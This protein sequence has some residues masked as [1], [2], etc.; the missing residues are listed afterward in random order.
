MVL[1]RI[2]IILAEHCNCI[3]KFCY[4][5]DMLSVCRLSV[6]G[7]YCDKMTEARITLFSLKSSNMSQLSA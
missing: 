1:V 6:T 7:M 5:R 3:A 2:N 4:C